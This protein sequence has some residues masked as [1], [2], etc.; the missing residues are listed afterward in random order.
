MPMNLGGSQDKKEPETESVKNDVP[1]FWFDGQHW[2]PYEDQW[3]CY[4]LDNDIMTPE[5]EELVSMTAAERA[6]RRERMVEKLSKTHERVKVCPD[7]GAVGF[8]APPTF[9][10]TFKIKS[11]ELSRNGHHFK[12]A[13]GGMLPNMGCK[14]VKALDVNANAN[15]SKWQIAKGLVKPLAGIIEMVRAGNKVILDEDAKGENVSRI[16]NKQSGIVIPI[17]QVNGQYEFDLFVPKEDHV[18]GVESDIDEV[19]YTGVW[20]ALADDDDEV[21]MRSTFIGLV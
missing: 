19:K 14:D 8:V 5:E 12:A 17:E 2:W 9:A 13:N 16:V 4:G 21:D 20:S 18:L 1:S 11:T 10:K 7:S 6:K 3:G 15:V